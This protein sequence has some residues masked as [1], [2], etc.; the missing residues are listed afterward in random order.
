VAVAV[1]RT[2]G[3]PRGYY[4]GVEH[5][6]RTVGSAAWVQSWQI[7]SAGEAA[8]AWVAVLGWGIHA[9]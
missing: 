7:P 2:W 4:R 1:G 3:S 9:V 6:L 8:K 5:A